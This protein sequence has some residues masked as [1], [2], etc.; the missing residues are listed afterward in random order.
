MPRF[1]EDEDLL[2]DAGTQ[3]DLDT[4]PGRDGNARGSDEW[5]DRLR[6][7]GFSDDEIAAHKRQFVPKA[8]FTR[9]T[10]QF[11]N[12]RQAMEQRFARLEAAISGGNGNGNGG[13]R[14]QNAGANLDEFDA[15]LADLRKSNP[16]VA[17]LLKRHGEAAAI[18]GARLAIQQMQPYINT[19]GN[20][21]KVTTAS[22][23]AQQRGRFIDRF[24]RE[25]AENWPEVE[26]IA[27]ELLQNGQ[28]VNINAIF[29]SLDEDFHDDCVARQ[30]ERKRRK[31]QEQRRHT[32]TEGFTQ[33]RTR[34]P[35][36]TPGIRPNPKDEDD[37]GVIDFRALAD[38]IQREVGMAFRR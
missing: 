35:M 9:K 15:E 20:V 16:D 3:D 6:E 12:D 8:V 33:Q 4:D 25:A 31:Q 5:E 24:G 13:G 28:P 22:Q 11:A 23:V 10:Q 1:L 29:Q 19:V 37:D 36:Q 7:R 18:K 32:G 2:D 21:V 14:A 26:R 27:N 30:R 38:E 17:D 34:T